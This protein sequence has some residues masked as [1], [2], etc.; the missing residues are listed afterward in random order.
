MTT[1]MSNVLWLLSYNTHWRQDSA[2]PEFSCIYLRK[3][4][5]W[6]R[7]N[8]DLPFSKAVSETGP[9]GCASVGSCDSDNSYLASH[10]KEA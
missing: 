8:L 4:P 6:Y 3:G 10:L 5:E 2:A 7:V 1:I 9:L